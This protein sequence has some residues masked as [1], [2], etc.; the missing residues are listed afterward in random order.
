MRTRLCVWPVLA[1][2]VLALTLDSATSNWLQGLLGRFRPGG[3]RGR[4][5]LDDAVV[6]AGLR[7]LGNTCYLN[8]VLQGLY[9]VREFRDRVIRSEFSRSSAGWE[10]QRV[11]R[12]LSASASSGGRATD[13]FSLVQKLDINV[14]I[15]EDAQEFYLRLLNLIDGDAAS[16]LADGSKV[17]QLFSGETEQTIKCV[18]VD[19][20]SSKKQKFLDLSLD[21]TIADDVDGAIQLL[22]RYVLPSTQC[23]ALYIKNKT[24]PN[25][26]TTHHI[27]QRKR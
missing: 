16:P 12:D 23:A 9:H 2:L 19:Y 13:P 5:R 6:G 17:S 18:A 20:Q 22:F 15:Q 7:N 25:L 21:A 8:S 1:F 10:L 14:A 3:G 11:F 27:T 26:N 4:S 24:C